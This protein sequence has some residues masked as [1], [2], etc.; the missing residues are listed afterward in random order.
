MYSSVFETLMPFM[1]KLFFLILFSD[2][3]KVMYGNRIDFCI[4]ILYCFSLV[5]SLE[6]LYTRLFYLQLMI[7]HL[8]FSQDIASFS[9]LT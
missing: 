1:C 2:F 9:F 8:P 4:E 5:D 3:L 7:V 6:F